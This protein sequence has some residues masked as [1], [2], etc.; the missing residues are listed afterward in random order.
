LRVHRAIGSPDSA[1]WNPDYLITVTHVP[2]RRWR[3]YVG[4]PRRDWV[5]EFVADLSDGTFV[6]GHAL[7]EST[8]G[9]PP[10]RV[11][12]SSADEGHAH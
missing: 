8:H 1:A 10:T 4:G 12:A 6:A 3:V 7:S 2:S 11:R 5:N 9:M